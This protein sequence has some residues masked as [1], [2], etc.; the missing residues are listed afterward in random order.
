MQ[1]VNQKYAAY[2]NRRYTRAGHLFQGRSKSVLVE[3]ETQL[4]VL[5]RYMHLNPVRAGM[6]AHP[7]EYAWSSYRAYVGLAK[8]P[9]WLHL[10]KTLARF[11]NR[12]SEQRRSYREFVEEGMAENPLREMRLGAVLGTEAFVEWAREKLQARAPDAEVA[13]LATARPRPTLEDICGV[14]AA[15]YGADVPDLRHKGRKRQEGRD[16]AMHLARELSGCSLKQIGSHFGGIQPSGV[17]MA[18]RR[19]AE[20]AKG[21]RSIRRE[22]ARLSRGLTDAGKWTSGA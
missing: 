1:W 18:C 9:A 13:R 17:S 3:A 7:A 15:T 20:K 4:H 19:V 14:V 21:D 10:A 2:V 8:P 6:V 5:T 22:V 12:L 16:V 11:G